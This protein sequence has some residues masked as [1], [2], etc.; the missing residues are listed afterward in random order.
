MLAVLQ[1]LICFVVLMVSLASVFNVVLL[2]ATEQRSTPEVAL[3]FQRMAS[4][5]TGRMEQAALEY[6]KI[7]P[8]KFH[9]QV[10]GVMND[11]EV[12][13]QIKQVDRLITENVYGFVI[14]PVDGRRLVPAL[15]RAHRKGIKVVVINNH[16][17]WQA[18]GR[19]QLL[20]PFVGPE[21]RLAAREA[22]LYLAG[23]L[24]KGDQV[25]ILKGKPGAQPSFE[26][27]NGFR[28]AMHQ[29]KLSIVATISAQGQEDKAERIA[30]KLISEFPALRAV[31]TTNDEMA[32]GVVKSIKASKAVDKVFVVGF[33]G[34]SQIKPYIESGSVLA[35][36]DS[37]SEQLA[38]EG[39]KK[40]LTGM[41]GDR[42]LPA[43]LLDRN[44]L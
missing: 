1:R 9:L 23:K 5:M 31:M 14:D 3:V 38:V 22:G 16:L 11:V 15:D 39:I 8:E 26:R 30:A 28:E 6:Q 7:H 17:D 35:T 29:R 13:Q 20:V 19:H 40:L 32:I 34:S 42:A 33:G 44:G 2:F 27:T 12:E 36:V 25:A 43:K 10:T 4:D 21:N 37:Q 18:M 24:E 41:R